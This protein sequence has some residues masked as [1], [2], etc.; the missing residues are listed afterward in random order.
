MKKNWRACLYA[1]ISRED[2]EKTES[3][4]ISAQRAL[5]YDFVKEHPAITI[6]SEQIDDG[7]SG[8]DFDR[9]GF[10]A[11]ISS[12]KTGLFDCI[13]VKDLSRFGRN[14]IETGR[15]VEQIFPLLG[16]RFIAITDNY[17]S[18]KA[19]TVNDSILLPFKNLLNDAYARDISIKV[20]SQ[21][22][23]KRKKGDFVGAFTVYGYAGD[24]IKTKF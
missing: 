7:Y 10:A 15:Y 11:M 20:R 8:V 22:E 21:L 3:N 23:A 18:A 24:I 14:W 12:I 17:D 4:S 19:G 9:P 6:C 1:R 5:I 16:V 13:I 2:A